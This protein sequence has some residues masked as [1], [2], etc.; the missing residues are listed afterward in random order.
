M[1]D[2][3]C[4]L[5]LALQAEG[6]FVEAPEHFRRAYATTPVFVGLLLML[7]RLRRAAGHL[8]RAARAFE[9]ALALDPGNDE[10]R[11]ALGELRLASA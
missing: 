9:D 2:T 11:I 4:G 8:R 3:P 10:A 5:G 6:R 1:L 7:G